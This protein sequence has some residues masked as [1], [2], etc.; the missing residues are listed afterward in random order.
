[1]T[2][3][4]KIKIQGFKSIRDVEFELQ[5]LNILIGPNGAGKSNFIG[6]FKILNNIVDENLQVYVGKSGGA[7]PLLYFGSTETSSINMHLWFK[8]NEYS[9]ALVP[10]EE[11]TLIFKS[12]MVYYHREPYYPRAYE[13]AFGSGHKESLIR[14]KASDAGG[15]SKY[16]LD[17]LKSWKIYHFHDTS[18]TARMRKLADVNDNSFL[19]HNASN[20][21]AYLYYLQKEHT[22]HYENIVDAIRL[23][24]PFFDDFNLKPLLLNKDKIGLEWRQ[25]GSDA[26]F[27]ASSLSDGT[28]RFMCLATL[29]LQPNLPTTILLDEPELGLHP[30]AVTILSELLKAASRKTQVIVS[31]QSVTLVNQFQPEDIVVVEMIDNETVMYRL[32]REKIAGWMEEYAIGELWEKNIFGGRPK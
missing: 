24:A 31:T 23:V 10:T 19:R 30:Y 20:M 26:Y 17:S 32:S 2:K 25:K 6:A 11:D 12:E 22:E 15:I 18:D 3:L 1:M 14:K 13:E 7:E 27:N 5:D 4:D 21:S 8:P 28:L 16:V 29:L 9:F